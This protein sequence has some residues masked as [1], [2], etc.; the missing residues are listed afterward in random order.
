M[1]QAYEYVGVRH[2]SAMD[3]AVDQYAAT[4]KAMA[5]LRI[6]IVTRHAVDIE[7]VR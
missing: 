5:Q 2:C 7:A 4:S 1:N 6:R 3:C